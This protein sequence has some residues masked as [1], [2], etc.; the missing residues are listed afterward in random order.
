MKSAP[1]SFAGDDQVVL[2]EP[3]EL[4]AL[5]R[6]QLLAEAREVGAR[7]HVAVEPS[8]RRLRRAVL[9]EQ[10]ADARGRRRR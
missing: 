2:L 4:L 9:L 1:A 5:E 7:H 10:A 6:V 3:R 8:P